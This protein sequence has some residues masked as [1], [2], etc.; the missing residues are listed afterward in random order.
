LS[1][2]SA[3][4]APWSVSPTSIAAFIAFIGIL[5]FVH[6]L[7]H[8]L[9]AKYFDVKVVKF[10]LGFGPPLIA[11]KKGETTY[12]IAAIPLGGF[13]KMVGDNPADD[14]APEDQARAFTTAPIYQRAIIAM[15]GPAFNLIFPVMCFFAYNVLGPKVVSPVVGQLE[16]GQPAERAGLKTGDRIVAVDGER[17]WSFKRLIELISVRPGEE[18]SLTI[19][20]EGKH[21]DAKVVPEAVQDVNFFGAPEVRGIIGVSRTRVGTRI[22]VA[23]AA[24][25]SGGFVTGDRILSID[26]KPVEMGEQIDPA[27]RAAAG[28]TIEVKVARPKSLASGDLLY[29]AAEDPAVLTVPV[30][31]GATGMADLGLAE[32]EAFVRG[33]V[34]GGA[35]DRAGLRPGDRVVAVAG[36]EVR[37]FW[38]LLTELK[39]AGKDPL[40]VTVERDGERKTLSLVAEPVECEH[41]VTKQSQVTYDPGIGIGPFA[42]GGPCM[43]LESRLQLFSHWSS[44]VPPEMEEAKLGLIEAFVSSVRQTGEV[45]GFVAI[46][47]FKLFSRQISMDNVGGPLQLFKLAAQ[48]AEVGVFAYLRTLAFISVNLGLINLLPIP[49]FDGGHLVFCAIE[50]VKRRPV[51]LRTRETAG[52]IGLVLLIALLVIALRNDIMNLGI[53]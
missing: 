40:E 12:Q 42:A 13:V 36:R 24:K 27:F 26:R 28:Q 30:P 25:N 7:G 4:D 3:V 50:A 23:V 29:A 17:V 19:E 45:I 18:V 2:T 8:F 31:E 15:A 37:L 53:F 47:L 9:A 1:Y 16:I 43:Q 38:S 41:E 35:A 32:S 49:I 11:F 10:S 48:A 44:T 21:I 51:S 39:R 34:P 20:R 22:G 46:G 14:I 6:E 33:I 52:L 5:I